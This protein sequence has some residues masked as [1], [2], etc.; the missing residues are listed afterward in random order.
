M[1]DREKLKAI[2]DYIRENKELHLQAIHDNGNELDKFMSASII[3][4]L[5][6]VGEILER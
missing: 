2:D 6:G 4:A 3:T 1:T 5:D